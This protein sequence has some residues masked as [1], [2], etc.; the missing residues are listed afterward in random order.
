MRL[1][2]NEQIELC[3]IVAEKLSEFMDARGKSMPSS[4][5]FE[6]IFGGDYCDIFDNLLDEL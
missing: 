3:N 5:I 4:E 2:T 1:S 6:M